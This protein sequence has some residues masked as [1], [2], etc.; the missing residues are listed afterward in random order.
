M[1]LSLGLGNVAADVD[2]HVLITLV[3][4]AS[5]LSAPYRRVSFCL[6]RRI[7]N[8]IECCRDTWRSGRANP[9]VRASFAKL[10]H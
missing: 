7:S 5:M 8:D 4:D 10:K 1:I 6:V 2:G 9:M 3:A